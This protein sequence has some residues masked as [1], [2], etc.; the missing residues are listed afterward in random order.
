MSRKVLNGMYQI[1]AVVD[2]NKIY[3][4]L[5]VVC[6]ISLSLRLWLLD[7]RWINPDEG[8]HLM[9]AVLVLEGN[10]PE[11]DF[12][13]RGPLYVY[14]IAGFLKLFG[15]NYI[16]GRL[17]PLT[18]SLLTGILV[19]LTARRLFDEKVALLSSVI[20]WMLP[21]ELM[22]SVVV[23]MQ[24]LV[25]LLTCLSI[26]SMVQSLHRRK[27][28]WLMI[29]GLFAAMGFY[30][31]ESALIIPLVVFGSLILFHR[32][33]LREVTKNFSFFLSG[34]IGFF[35]LVLTCY[36]RFMSTGALITSSLSPF[37]FLTS[38]VKKAISVNGGLAG[39]AN[40]LTS[41]TSDMSWLY[42][43]YLHEAF[44][45]HSFLL[46]GLGFSAVTAGRYLLVSNRQEIWREHL[47]PHFILYLWVFFLF[48]SYGFYFYTRGFFIDYFREFLPPLA[49]I[50]AA[51]IRYSVPSLERK[52]V[53]EWLIM[54][55]VCL[56][57]ILFFLQSNYQDIFGIG[58]HASLTIAIFT[59]F[60][61]TKVFKPSSRRL[62]FVSIILSIV[63]LIL[64]SR[65]A[66]M[67]LYLSGTV[68]SIGTI[69]IIYGITWVLLGE[70]MRP[71]WVSYVK[72][73]GLSIALG[74]L[75]V[76]ISY[77]AILLNLA[78]DSPWS[79]QSV[80][81]TAAYLRT[82]TSDN[83]EVMSGAVIWELQARRKPFQMISHPLVF[84]NNMSE[85]ERDALRFTVTTRP[86]KV[87]ILDGYTEKTYIRQVP[88]IMELLHTDYE[89]M[90]TV[91]P[92][93]YPTGAYKLPVRV[94]KLKEYLR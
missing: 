54:V 22:N 91:D 3:I 2:S 78:Y 38:I 1:S 51:W 62:V 35:L 64:I 69:A 80:E 60:T 79:P 92:V 86:P 88:R 36:G 7:K 39:P 61:F 13:S 44:N 46:I 43:R 26:Y 5:L 58:F 20:Y 34:Y 45:L 29:A 42:Y 82:Y 6:L 57:G 93:K 65:Q 12:N 66:P 37:G 14:A 31:R 23:K 81:K 27:G 33:R 73:V 72:F 59:L 77:S 83:D 67:K 48:I 76:S 85:K 87:I 32:W 75:V 18:C 50:F 8:A 21:L 90:T 16:S 49:I 10:I 63:V 25:A 9:D 53:L 74:S 56:S 24:P 19:F 40:V 94:Y 89:L 11:V 47:I 28:L 68:P 30:V 52:G 17:L 71:P 15:I 70:K 84:E 4:L 41:Q 55:G